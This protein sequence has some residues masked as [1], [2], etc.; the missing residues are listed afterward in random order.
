V[1][2]KKSIHWTVVYV[3]VLMTTAVFQVS[4]DQQAT[5]AKRESHYTGMVVSVDQKEHTLITKGLILNRKFN[6]GDTCAYAL[7]DIDPGTVGDLRPGEKVTVSYQN[8]QS[9]LIADRVEQQPMRFEGMVTAIDPD[10][11]T[12]TIHRQTSDKQLRIADGCMIVLRDEKPGTFAD[13]RVGDHVTITYE[14]PG[15][16]LTVR[17]IAPMSIVFTGTLTAIDLGERTLKAEAMF[18]TKEF[19][20]ADHCAIVINGKAEGQLND[21]KPNDRLVLNYD[22]INGINVVNR[23]ALA[24][25]QKNPAAST[26]STSGY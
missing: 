25:P 3:V 9:V 17:E 7:L 26:V 14:T 5:A 8:A 2:T 21:L 16:M 19:N 13:V 12:L 1:K 11:H 24:E 18:D 6:L 23:I 15:G 4:A 10:K 20:V 22:E